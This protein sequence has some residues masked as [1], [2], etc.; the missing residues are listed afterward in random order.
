M[1]KIPEND[2]DVK[3]ILREQLSLLAEASELNRYGVS[4]LVEL[5]KA[6]NEIAK[7]LLE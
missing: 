2:K 7:I 4:C 5:T 1:K 3:K 6:M